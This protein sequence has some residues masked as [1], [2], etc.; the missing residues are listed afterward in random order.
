MLSYL[1]RCSQ[2]RKA[3]ETCSCQDSQAGSVSKKVRVSSCLCTEHGDACSMQSYRPP[4]MAIVCRSLQNVPSWSFSASLH[5]RWQ[6]QTVCR[7][8]STEFMPSTVQR[9]T[10]YEEHT[11]E[12]LQHTFT[13]MQLSRVGGAHDGGVDLVGWWKDP[14]ND[15]D[16]P[17]IRV[18]AQCKSESKKLGPIHI[19]EI[20]GTF[21]SK[22]FSDVQ[23]SAAM[24]VISSSSGFS[25]QCLLQAQVSSTPLL[26][27]HLRHPYDFDDSDTKTKESKGA[28]KQKAIMLN[29]CRSS[30]Y[31]LEMALVND[32]LNTTLKSQLEVKYMT[33]S[34]LTSGRHQESHHVYI[35]S[36]FLQGQKL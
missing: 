29:S 36:L 23:P 8:F 31:F 11:L 34:P 17:R 27:I 9:G 24:A 5:T 4:A 35:P 18:M 10:R 26:L 25:K 20:Q 15:L 16:L 32:A 28:K 6:T 14:L 33:S 13:S 12:Y 21:T 7:S 30:N 1:Y 3:V 19:R 22:Y 2:V